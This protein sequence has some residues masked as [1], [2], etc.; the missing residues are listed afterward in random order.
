MVTT[1]WKHSHFHQN[2]ELI[3]D[4]NIMK[5]YAQPDLSL[6]FPH[7]FPN[8]HMILAPTTLHMKKINSWA[9]DYHFGDW[10]NASIPS[11]ELMIDFDHD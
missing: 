8:M 4:N 2:N 10:D 7:L 3:M 9:R 6:S 1:D 5:F 11:D